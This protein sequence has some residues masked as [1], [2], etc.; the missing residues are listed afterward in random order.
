M[1]LGGCFTIANGMERS[2]VSRAIYVLLSLLKNDPLYI[3]PRHYRGLHSACNNIPIIVTCV[4]FNT[5]R[6]PIISTVKRSPSSTR[7]NSSL[8][9]IFISRDKN[10]SIGDTPP[11][12]N[13]VA[14]PRIPAWVIVFAI[15]LI[16][17][18]SSGKHTRQS[19][20]TSYRIFPADNVP[21]EYLNM[22]IDPGQIYPSIEHL[23]S[24]RA[25]IS[26]CKRLFISLFR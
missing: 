17:V 21:H 8:F 15:H 22:E 11:T 6:R 7:Q 9:R 10:T 3:I 5:N 14:I 16:C 25:A 23:P 12:C 4:S 18:C 24:Y 20:T 13:L 26:S 2:G 1:S 19:A